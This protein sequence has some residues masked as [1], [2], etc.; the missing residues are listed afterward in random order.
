MSGLSTGSSRRRLVD[1]FS[2]GAV[3]IL[4]DVEDEGD[5]VLL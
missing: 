2:A 3:P 4:V 1:G 5:L